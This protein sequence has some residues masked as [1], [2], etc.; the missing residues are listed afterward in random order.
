MAATVSSGPTTTDGGIEPDAD[1]N[2]DEGAGQR[3][4]QLTGEHCLATW[5]GVAPS[6]RTG[7]DGYLASSTVA[8]AVKIALTT[9]KMTSAT[10]RTSITWLTGL[11]GG[12]PAIAAPPGGGWLWLAR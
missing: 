10:V 3:G 1:R 4:Q 5:P 8:Q 6:V 9:A 7:A 2:P 11:A 12:P